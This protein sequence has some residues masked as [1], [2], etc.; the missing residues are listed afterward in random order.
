MRVIER[1]IDMELISR[2]ALYALMQA[3]SPVPGRAISYKA[4]ADAA[5]NKMRT[6]GVKRSV[7]KS[8]V[9]HLVTGHIKSTNQ[10]YAKAICAALDVPLGALFVTRVSTVQRD[11]PKGRAA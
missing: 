1:R 5:T 10:D 11:V 4:L 2:L 9:G 6:A 3:K 7:S 8:T